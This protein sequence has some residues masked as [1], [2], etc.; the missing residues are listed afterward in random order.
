M[1]DVYKQ[2]FPANVYFDLSE[3]FYQDFYGYKQANPE[4]NLK[5]MEILPDIPENNLCYEAKHLGKAIEEAPE[6]EN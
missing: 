5:E 4:E 3:A 1:G 6:E 2:K